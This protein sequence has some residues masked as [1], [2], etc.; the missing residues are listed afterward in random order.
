MLWSDEPSGPAFV[1]G[2]SATP[3]LFWIRVEQLLDKKCTVRVCSPLLLRLMKAL[4]EEHEG[5]RWLVV[6]PR[7]NRPSASRLFRLRD[8]LMSSMGL[9]LALPLLLLLGILIKLTSPGPVFFS[10]I[11]VGQDRRQFR[12]YKL[13]SMRV[14]PEDEDSSQRRMRFEAFARGD[15]QRLMP[16]TAHRTKVIDQSRVTPIGKWLRRYSLDELPQLWNVLRGEMTLVGPRPCLPYEA[17]FFRGWRDRRF[18][19]P[20]GMTGVWQVFGRGEASFD[21]S[22]AMDVYYVFRKS[23]F[24]DLYLIFRTIGKVFTGKGAM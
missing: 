16:E 13:R 10:T 22:T 3:E 24:F 15:N 23:L 11:V 19:V 7:T 8:V 14:V 6:K 5:H 21:E 2:Q 1:E 12:W 4:A 20:A 9:L 17:P 18:N